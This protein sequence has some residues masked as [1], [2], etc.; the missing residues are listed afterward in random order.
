MAFI[1]EDEL[2]SFPKKFSVTERMLAKAAASTRTASTVTTVFVSHSHEDA[3]FVEPVILLLE[4]EGVVVYVDWKDS[5]MPKVTSPETA[6]QIKERIAGCEKFLVVG[7]NNAAGSRWIPWELGVAD[8]HRGLSNIAILPVVPQY[9]RWEGQEY[10]GIYSR[11]ERAKDGR[12]AV[13]PAG[14][15]R[16]KYLDDWLKR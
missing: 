14:E 1:T 12:W 4:N 5:S 10:I 3:E 16:G 7:T 2:R 8:S 6:A 15:N 11:L 13:F 9:R